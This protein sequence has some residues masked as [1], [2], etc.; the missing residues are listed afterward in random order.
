MGR[1][2]PTPLA[3][4]MSS[5]MPWNLSASIRGSSARPGAAA[6]FS[7]GGGGGHASSSIAGGPVGFLGGRVSR[8]VSA[9]PLIGYGGG[10]N[11]NRDNF[12]DYQIPGDDYEGF[13]HGDQTGAGTRD[14]D[15]DADAVGLTLSRRQ[16]DFELFGVAAAVDTQTAGAPSWVRQALD[17]ESANFLSFVR[18]GIE[19]ADIAREGVEEEELEEL[20]QKGSVLFEELLPH[21][22]NSRI[23]AAQALL[24]VLTL[25]TKNMLHAEQR[26]HFQAISMRI[27]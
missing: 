3:D 4:N 8:V 27:S 23:V 24:H 9:S 20:D 11:D 18:A 26:D 10:D 7:V 5:T 16:E 6:P 17:S 13:E 22:E 14:G 2:A 12:D 19:E 1:E 25:A 15:A 21:A